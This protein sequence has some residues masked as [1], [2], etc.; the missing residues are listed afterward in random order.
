M[1]WPFHKT[2]NHLID[3]ERTGPDLGKRTLYLSM[4][5]T[6]EVARAKSSVQCHIPPPEVSGWGRPLSVTG[7]TWVAPSSPWHRWPWAR[8][9]G[10]NGSHLL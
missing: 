1:T 3:K 6:E 8:R 2:C 5:R 9:S 7:E 10:G 4:R